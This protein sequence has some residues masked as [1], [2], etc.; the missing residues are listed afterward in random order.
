MLT[1]L[2]TTFGSKTPEE[3]DESL[4]LVNLSNP[5]MEEYGLEDSESESDIEGAGKKAAAPAT[6]GAISSVRY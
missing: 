2:R 6:I 1:W 4:P 5:R 3:E